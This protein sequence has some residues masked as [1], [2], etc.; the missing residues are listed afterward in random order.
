MLIYIARRV[1]A[2]APVLFGV[3]L[4][5]FSM[6]FLV[7]GDP[8]KIMLAEFVTTP[9][10]IER[11]RA[12]LHLDEPVLQQYGRFVGN[13]LRGDLGTSESIARLEPDDE[14]VVGRC[15]RV[16]RILAEQAGY[17][18]RGYRLTCNTGPEGGQVVYH[19][20]LHLT[21]GRRA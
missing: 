9:E 6:L 17:G 18:E 16:A 14:T 12:Q 13:A 10:Q 11:M 1:F 8:V 20:H 19:L 2:V 3:T 4:A 21:A 15:V 7:P 5:V